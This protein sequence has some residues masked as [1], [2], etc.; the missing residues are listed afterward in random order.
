MTALPGLGPERLLSPAFRPPLLS[1]LCR[2]WGPAPSD[3]NPRGPGLPLRRA[4]AVVEPPPAFLAGQL[5]WPLA[6]HFAFF[7]GPGAGSRARNASLAAPTGH[8]L[9]HCA[10][11]QFPGASCALGIVGDEGDSVI[12]LTRP[13]AL[14]THCLGTS[15]RK[16]NGFCLQ[17]LAL[18]MENLRPGGE[19]NY[20]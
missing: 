7:S 18:Q 14:G 9:I 17:L 6:P 2:A 11:Q 10:D 3:L 5:S 8:S 19:N 12:H 16:G 15:Q 4:L 20:V 1:P 13:L